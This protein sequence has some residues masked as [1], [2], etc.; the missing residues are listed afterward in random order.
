M[1]P[2]S[3]RIQ[4]YR[5]QQRPGGVHH[6]ARS[7]D[8]P[9]GER[10][11]RGRE[12]DRRGS[13]GD[14]HDRH[15]DRPVG[16]LDASDRT[17]SSTAQRPRA[18]RSRWNSTWRATSSSARGS[19]TIYAERMYYDVRRQIGI[20]LEAELLTPLPNYQ[21]LLRLRSRVL[22]QTGEGRFHAEESFL[23]SSRFGVPGYRIQLGDLDYEDVA[24]ADVRSDHGP[25]W[26]STRRPT[27]RSSSRSSWPRAATP[28]CSSATCRSS[29]GPTSPPT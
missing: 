18:T 28:S 12:R 23:T 15:L 6:V 7:G 2:G 14:R 8:G 5:S 19:R 1:P 21:G 29:I 26:R 9:M 3:R 11:Q 17:N 22:Q 4:F 13:V 27:S 20:V 16:D 10:G 24:A 25:A